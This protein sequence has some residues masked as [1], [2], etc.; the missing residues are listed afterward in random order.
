MFFI[1]C[2]SPLMQKTRCRPFPHLFLHISADYPKANSRSEAAAGNLLQACGWLRHWAHP[3]SWSYERYWNKNM[4]IATRCTANLALH[5][6]LSHTHP[7]PGFPTRLS[8]Y[9]AS[10]IPLCGFFV[11]TWLGKQ[12]TFAHTL[13]S[14]SQKQTH[15]SVKVLYTHLNLTDDGVLEYWR[16]VGGVHVCVI[17]DGRFITGSTDSFKLFG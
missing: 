3:G 10:Y 6:V 15:S 7:Q 2:Y 13:C 16:V 9:D 11:I 14:F 5:C 8:I 17:V 1:G 12:H 4:S